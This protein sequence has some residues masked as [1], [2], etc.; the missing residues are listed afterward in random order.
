LDI[1]SWL[2]WIGLAQYAEL[3]RAND[4]DG[5]LLGRLTSDD[6]KE[7]GVASLG[8]RK[9]LLEAIATLGAVAE[10]PSPTPVAATPTPAAE[11]RQLTVMF[12]DQG[13]RPSDGLIREE[14]REVLRAYQNTVAG[15]ISRM[16]ASP[17]RWH[18]ARCFG[19]PRT[20]EDAAGRRGRVGGVVG[21]RLAAGEP[22][23]LVG[24]ATAL[25]SL[26]DHRRRRHRS[27]RRYAE[28]CRT[29]GAAEPG[30]S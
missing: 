12:V 3:F 28:P 9:Q 13:R 26:G 19:W 8:H 25:W 1:D 30:W 17:L 6:L 18:A 20:H 16:K 22:C 24:I 14:M 15:E 11:R 10:A 2:R 4:I 21:D 23:R 27:R 5:E 7:I 29:P